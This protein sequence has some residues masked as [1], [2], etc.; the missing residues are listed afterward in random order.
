VTGRE[1]PLRRALLAAFAQDSQAALR[2]GMYAERAQA[3]GLPQ[4]ARLWRAL[5]SG[6]EIHAKRRLK[7]ARALGGSA[8]NLEAG[9]ALEARQAALARRGA[10]L[11]REAG[12]RL[13]EQA[14]AWAEGT[15]R[16]HAELLEA[17]R[18][19]VAHGGDA[20]PGDLLLCRVCGYLHEGPEP[21]DVCP[22]C[23]SPARAFRSLPPV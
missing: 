10:A 8:A 22:V 3:Q 18:A 21:P 1:H 13:A 23:G 16:R 11:A 12:H 19:A 14:F 20:P 4:L 6:E 17:V 15:D 2:Y 9:L 7:A 5:A